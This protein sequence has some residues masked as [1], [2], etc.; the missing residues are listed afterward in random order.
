MTTKFFEALGCRRPI[1]CVKS[2]EDILE[3]TIIKTNS[4]VAARTVDEAEDFILKKY[5]EWKQNGCTK[6]EANENGFVF[7]RSQQAQ[8]Y[9]ELL[10]RLT[11]KQ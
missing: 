3:Q 6:Q 9:L 2:D 10:N 4:G 7:S 8:Q 11:E 1:L 5:E